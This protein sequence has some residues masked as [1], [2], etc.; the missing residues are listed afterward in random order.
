MPNATGNREWLPAWPALGICRSSP[1]SFK[2][3]EVQEKGTWIDTDAPSAARSSTF[4]TP[5]AAVPLL[6]DPISVRNAGAFSTGSLRRMSFPV[7]STKNKRRVRAREYYYPGHQHSSFQESQVSKYRLVDA[8]TG[9]ILRH[10]VRNLRDAERERVWY[11]DQTGREI[12]I[13]KVFE[14]R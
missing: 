5:A 9:M 6:P 12:R 7:N 3:D 8:K 2:P 11:E 14:T 1:G 13:V 10:Y 4:R